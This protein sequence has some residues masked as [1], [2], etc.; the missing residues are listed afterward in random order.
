VVG[1]QVWFE[2]GVGSAGSPMTKQPVATLTHRGAD[3]AP[4]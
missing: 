2:V 4:R 1:K 3:A